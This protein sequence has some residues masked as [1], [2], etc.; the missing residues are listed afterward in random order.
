MGVW[1]A[2]QKS[3]CDFP[4]HPL[5][6]RYNFRTKT[7]PVSYGEYLMPIANIQDTTGVELKLQEILSSADVD[8]RLQAIRE[9]FVGILDY[10]NA[11]QL[12]SLKSAGNAQ[13]PADAH[14]AARRDG[15]SVAYIPL[16]NA[17]TNKVNGKG[18]YN[19][20]IFVDRLWRTVKYEEVCLKAYANAIEAREGSGSLLQVLQRPG[21]PSSP[22]LPDHNTVCL[23]EISAMEL[24]RDRK[25]G[26]LVHR[27]ELVSQS[28][29]KIIR[30]TGIKPGGSLAGPARVGTTHHHHGPR[31]HFRAG[32]TTLAKAVSAD[33]RRGPPRRRPRM[34][35]DSG[36]VESRET[37]GLHRHPIPPGPGAPQSTPLCDG[38][39][40]GDPD[41]A[42]RTQTPLPPR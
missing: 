8:R 13:L 33:G 42:D 21:A 14:I 16:D 36:A 1:D 24:R 22:G 37:A 7:R 38:D 5:P 20:N 35:Q 34:D 10:D 29:E 23:S 18:R 26:L 6:L 25:I 17:T 9:L 39:K 15:V 32:D 4:Y 28:E 2:G 27:Q 31:H 40:T 11:D 3:Q 19:D 41:G 12:V 30:Q